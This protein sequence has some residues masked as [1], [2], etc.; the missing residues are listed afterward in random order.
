MVGHLL[1]QTTP[2][3]CPFSC[4]P[5]ELQGSGVEKYRMDGNNNMFS[6]EENKDQD[7]NGIFIFNKTPIHIHLHSWLGYDKQGTSAKAI[8]VSLVYQ[9]FS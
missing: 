5:L 6:S 2:F 4:S 8:K 1:T 7:K 3:V 9:S